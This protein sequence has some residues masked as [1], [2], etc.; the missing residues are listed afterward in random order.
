MDVDELELIKKR[1]HYQSWVNSQQGLYLPDNLWL[2]SALISGARNRRKQLALYYIMWHNRKPKVI[3]ELIDDW[4]E[5]N[6][7]TLPR[8]VS[9]SRF[10]MTTNE[11]KSFFWRNKQIFDLTPVR[12]EYGHRDY[13]YNIKET[14]K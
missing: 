4:I 10:V 3:K 6:L 9:P 5:F 13:L 14:I 7:S 11:I 8:T 1:L 2:S 12:N